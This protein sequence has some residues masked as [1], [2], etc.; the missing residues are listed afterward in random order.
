LA[1]AHLEAR[2][3]RPDKTVINLMGDASLGIATRSREAV[4]E[5]IP[6]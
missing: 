4:R 1:L 6:I 2:A 5:R 3:G